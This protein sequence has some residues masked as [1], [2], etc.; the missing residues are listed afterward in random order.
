MFW[1]VWIFQ[2]GCSL[3]SCWG[4]YD[5]RNR[6]RLGSSARLRLGLASS[7]LPCCLSLSPIYNC[8]PTSVRITIDIRF[9]V[10]PY[11]RN[12]VHTQF[13]PVCVLSIGGWDTLLLLSVL[14]VNYFPFSPP[15]FPFHLPLPSLANLSYPRH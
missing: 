1:V 12:L 4:V 8:A 7:I 14:R 3:A 5:T 15:P 10:I 9:F 13:N 2:F 6:S 11:T